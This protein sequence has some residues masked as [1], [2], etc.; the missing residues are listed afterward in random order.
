MLGAIASAV[1]SALGDL[2]GIGLQAHEG[3]RSAATQMDFQERMRATQYQ[4]A[5]KDLEAAGLNRVLAL[6]QPAGTPSGSG[7]SVDAPKL[8]TSAVQAASAYQAIQVQKEQAKLIQS[9]V[10]REDSQKS[11]ND[12]NS[13][14]AWTEMQKASQ[15]ISNLVNQNS[16]ITAQES[17]VRSRIA[18]NTEDARLKRAEAAKQ[19]LLKAGYDKFGPRLIRL[20]DEW[21]P[22]SSAKPNAER[23]KV[24]PGLSK[25]KGRYNPLGFDFDD[26]RNLFRR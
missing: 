4:T 25:P 9:Q 24:L 11:L 6:G 3:R 23:P 14:K 16:L 19:E 17:E 10:A 1:G 8:G 15:E 22:D 5:A 18:V 26:F 12:V 7:Y 13:A 21:F 20:L 2:A